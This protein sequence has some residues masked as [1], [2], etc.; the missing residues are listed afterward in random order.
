MH[1]FGAP[2]KDLF[3]Q[4]KRKKNWELALPLF[5]TLFSFI[6]YTR[7][8]VAIQVY[9]LYT[10]VMLSLAQFSIYLYIYM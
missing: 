7:A 5:F 3:P 1:L 9:L 2:L 8:L 6:S 4:K 10:E